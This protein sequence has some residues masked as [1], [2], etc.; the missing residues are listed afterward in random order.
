MVG[1]SDYVGP[2]CVRGPGA[3]VLDGLKRDVRVEGK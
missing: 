1:V 2:N 3:L